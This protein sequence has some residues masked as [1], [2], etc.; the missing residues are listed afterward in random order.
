MPLPI[1]LRNPAYVRTYPVLKDPESSGSGD[2]EAPIRESIDRVFSRREDGSWTIGE[3]ILLRLHTKRLFDTDIVECF[4]VTE[5]DDAVIDGGRFALLARD[6]LARIEPPPSDRAL[7][8]SDFLLTVTDCSDIVRY[9]DPLAYGL[10]HKRLDRTH[11]V[12]S[13]ENDSEYL[14]NA[15]KNLEL[16]AAYSEKIERFHEKFLRHTYPEILRMHA[17]IVADCQDILSAGGAPRANDDSLSRLNQEILRLDSLNFGLS[18]DIESIES[19]IDN[20]ESRIETIGAS[21]SRYFDNFVRKAI[22]A[23]FL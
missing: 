19:N 4:V 2:P 8:S 13:L 1:P 22:H 3:G 11:I 10:A 5:S 7:P 23:R 17:Q 21:G 16:I 12:F 20:L 14:G 15:F 18:Y 6:T 9:A